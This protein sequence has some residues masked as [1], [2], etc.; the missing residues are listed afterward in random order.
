M[1]IR[2]FRRVFDLERRIYRIDR[3]RLNPGGVPLRVLVYFLTLLLACVLAARL[4]VVGYPLAS[5]PAYLRDLALPALGAWALTALRVDGRPG[6][7]AAYALA[8]LWLGPRFLIGGRLRA[9]KHQLWWPGEVVLLPDQREA[10]LRRMRY[11]GPGEA[12]IAIGH[13]RRLGV[14]ALMLTSRRTRVTVSATAATR[15][16]RSRRHIVLPQ[17][18]RMDLAPPARARAR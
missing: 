11:A 5:A 6:H 8:R 12:V 3:L 18:G 1:E 9:R 10:G 14:P 13:R 15:H 7:T 2:S 4:P 16:P 17:G